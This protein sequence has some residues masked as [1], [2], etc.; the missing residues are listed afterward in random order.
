MILLDTNI[1]LYAFGTSFEQHD[2]VRVWLDAALNGTT[3]VGMPWS[4]LVGFVRI[5]S[6][7]GAFEKAVSVGEA[8]AIV[9]SWLDCPVVW[10]PVPADGHRA[11]LGRMLHAIGNRKH[12][13]SDAHLAALAIEN[14]L[15]L[16]TTDGDFARFPGLRWEN[17]LQR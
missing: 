14:S 3:R 13:V 17:P 1:L 7:P 6:N 4:S 11:I 9:E 16:C 10:V 15:T 8:W 5:A 12:L 2:R